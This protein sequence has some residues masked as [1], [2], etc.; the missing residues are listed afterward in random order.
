MVAPR[1]H[2]ADPVQPHAGGRGGAPTGGHGGHEGPGA[3]PPSVPPMHSAAARDL[4]RRL[5]LLLSWA[6]WRPESWVDLLD[7]VLR[8]MGVESVRAR[9]AT[10]AER[11]IR[12]IPVHIA[13]VDLRIP[14]RDQPASPTAP[15]AAPEEGGPRILEL[16]RRL[17]QPPPTVVVKHTRTER[18]DSRHISA[19]LRSDAFAV[20]DRT[21]VNLE[22]MLRI[23]QRVLQRFYEDR[24]P[25]SAGPEPGRG[26][27]DPFG[28]F[29]RLT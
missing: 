5:N 7:G 13:V 22:Q 4:P 28:G 17:E 29:R 12:T 15:A 8:P 18:D 27:P 2:S 10:E 11:V 6:D 14:L 24:W 23:M 21:G 1:P 3:P 26:G 16:L 20:V 9:S 25:D 19:A